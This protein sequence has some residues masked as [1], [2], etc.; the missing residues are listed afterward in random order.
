M[1]DGAGDR[2]RAT[3]PRSIQW[4]EIK[5]KPTRTNEARQ[6]LRMSESG[7]GSTMAEL[8]EARI[9]SRRLVGMEIASG[10]RE[11]THKDKAFILSQIDHSRQQQTHSK[12]L[13]SS[14]LVAAIFS[15]ISAN[16]EWTA[17]TRLQNCELPR[18][19]AGESHPRQRP[20]G[21]PT[22]ICRRALAG[23]KTGQYGAYGNRPIEAKPN[24]TQ[25]G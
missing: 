18:V 17:S 16:F 14:Q 24:Q 15:P 3:G 1:R 23:P 25:R 7:V 6:V 12:Y 21:R 19:Q 8:V 5:R 2:T 10:C 13:L 4:S 20:T 22:R 9:T 11:R